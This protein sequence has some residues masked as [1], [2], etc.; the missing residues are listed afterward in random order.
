MKKRICNSIA[1]LLAFATSAMALCSFAYAPCFAE[2]ENIAV[3][4]KL[5]EFEEKSEYEISSAQSSS[6]T[7][8]SNTYGEFLLNGNIKTS[9]SKNGV[10]SYEVEDGKLSFVYK[11][12]DTLLNADMDSWHLF[13]D[14]VNKIDG[15]VLANSV[16]KG[17]I[18]L[19]T[20]MDRLNWTDAVCMTN[21]FSSTPICSDS[22]YESKDIEL[23]NGCYYKVI[24]AY[25]TR[26][27]TEDSNF[28]FV[29]TDK[30]DYKKYAEVY[31][32]YA[33]TGSS[34]EKETIDY[35]QTYNIG[36]RVRTKNFDGYY[37]E[38]NI[39]KNDIDRKSVGRERVC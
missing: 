14:G 18:L 2:N 24:V 28:W 15:Q 23:I 21:V 10:P 13:S 38:E 25:E 37:G 29:D 26:I 9:T 39:A 20:S 17:T 27:R 3:V 33:Y 1:R 22:F 30:F 35:S 6:T 19:Q 16:Q 34:N 12:D 5:Y 32:F 31:E 4:G 11:Y 8:S 7:T 36:S